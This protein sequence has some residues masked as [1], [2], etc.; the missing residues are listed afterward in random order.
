LQPIGIIMDF[1]IIGEAKQAVQVKLKEGENVIAGV[2]TLAWMQGDIQPATRVK[3]GT[4]GAAGRAL[5]PEMHYLSTYHCQNGNGTLTFTAPT[6]GKLLE[7]ELKVDE[8]LICRQGILLVAAGS[9]SVLVDIQENIGMGLLSQTN[10]VVEQY[11]GPGKLYLALSGDAYEV[12]LEE[13]KALKAD[14]A[15]VACYQPNVRREVEF[16][17]GIKP[18]QSNG[19]NLYLVNFSGAGKVWLQSPGQRTPTA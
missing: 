9:L 15:H 5:P 17:R 7:I 2:G 12:E 13:G 6:P 4:S 3:D 16:V 1:E 10:L 11:S 14:P 8:K 19:E 18:I